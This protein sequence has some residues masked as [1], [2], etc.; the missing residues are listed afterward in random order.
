MSGDFNMEDFV[1]SNS[2]LNTFSRC[3]KRYFYKYEMGW[4]RR[5]KKIQLERGSW[6]HKLLE[7]YYKG[8]DWEAEHKRLTKEFYKLFEEE[9]IDLGDMP[10]DCRRLMRAYLRTYRDDFDRYN[11]VDT[12]LDETVTFSNG[13][14]MRIIIDLILE[15]KQTGFL[16]AWDHKS[17]ANFAD[18][19]NMVLDPQLTRYYRGLEILGYKPLGGVGYNEL[20]TKPPTI[21]QLVDVNRHPRLSQRKDIDTDVYTYMREIKRHGFDP[22]DYADI[23]RLIAVRQTGKFFRRTILP[24]DPPMIRTMMKETVQVV[25]QIGDAHRKNRFPRTFDKSCSWCD[26]KDVCIAQLHGANVAPLVKMNFTTREQRERKKKI[27]RIKAKR[28]AE[29]MKASD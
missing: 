12:E 4:E 13:M 29:R 1:A 15:D 22:S 5:E 17:R 9:R 16:F 21:P 8:G 26:F 2:R 7:V 28:A 10:T 25:G 3:P 27:E 18:G 11:V 24:K 14:A 6:M 23:L 20:R 19:D